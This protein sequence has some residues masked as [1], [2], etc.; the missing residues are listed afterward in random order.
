MSEKGANAS[1]WQVSNSST[2]K[3]KRLGGH[4][5][6]YN[7]QRAWPLSSLLGSISSINL[8]TNFDLFGWQISHTDNTNGVNFETYGYD[9]LNRL[10]SRND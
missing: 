9:S 10:A 1:L 5:R 3:P 2:L 6:H 8:G 7:Q 4:Q